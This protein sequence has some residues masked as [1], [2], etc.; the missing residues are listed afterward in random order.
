MHIRM[1]RL[2]VGV[3]LIQTIMVQPVRADWNYTFIPTFSLG[4]EYD[5]NIYNTGSNETDDW[6]YSGAATF[7]FRAESPDTSV[8]LNYRNGYFIYSSEEDADYGNHFVTFDASHAL[9]RRLNLSVTDSYSSTKD[10]D[11]VL[12]SETTEGETG[13]IGERVR[14]KSNTVTGVMAYSLSQ[15]ATLSLS[16]V[17]SFYRYSHDSSYDSSTNG[18]GFSFDYGLTPKDSLVISGSLRETD[19]ERSD[20]HLTDNASYGAL[21]PTNVAVGIF[22]VPVPTF[23]LGF[24]NEFDRSDDYSARI[25][26]ARQFSSTLEATISVGARWTKDQAE[27]LS[28]VSAPGSSVEV[29]NSSTIPAGNLVRYFDPISGTMDTR[30]LSDGRIVF[31]NAA[32]ATKDDTERERGLVYNLTISK[33][34]RVSS[35]TLGLSQDTF[36]RTALGGTGERQSYTFAYNHRLSDRLSAFFNTLYSKNKEESDIRDDK[37]QTLRTGTGFRFEVTRHL[38][39][40]LSWSHS[41]QKRDLQNAITGPRIERD[42]VSLTFT[43]QWPMER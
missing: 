41:V 27:V 21:A 3:L 26:W 25:G 23:G 11:R 42:L 10:S 2:F 13:I 37:Y 29:P 33:N 18:G 31:N 35:L 7:P 39:S 38:D 15:R 32:L 5:S 28:L 22:L 43:Y 4:L 36:Q 17:N 12:R 9:T 1:L 14:R 6:N 19:Y 34:F 16:G 24:T 30:V 8:G 20:R 40:R